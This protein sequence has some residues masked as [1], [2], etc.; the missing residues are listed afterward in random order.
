MKCLDCS[1]HRQCVGQ[2]RTACTETGKCFLSEFS[3]MM[4]LAFVVC[5]SHSILKHYT[6][7]LQLYPKAPL[8]FLSVSFI[9]PLKE[10]RN[11]WVGMEYCHSNL[12]QL[13]SNKCQ[14]AFYWQPFLCVTCAEGFLCHALMENYASFRT[15]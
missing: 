3:F 12:A 14:F 5:Q 8:S 10:N 7:T 11:K 1:V 15:N 9:L 6:I 13:H 4:F 2:G